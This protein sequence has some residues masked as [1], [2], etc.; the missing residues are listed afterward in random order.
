LQPKAEISQTSFT[1]TSIDN[2]IGK[3]QQQLS[4]LVV[5][6]IDINCHPIT[7]RGSQNT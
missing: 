7:P 5:Y 4:Q 3:E 1:S 2:C 6:I